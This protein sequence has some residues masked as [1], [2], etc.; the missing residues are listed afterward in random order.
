MKNVPT[1]FLPLVLLLFSTSFALDEQPSKGLLISAVGLPGSGKSSVMKEL[2]TL[3]DRTC[4]CEPDEKDWADAVLAKYMSGSFTMITWF[5]SMRVPQLYRAHQLRTI[6]EIAITDSYYDKLLSCYIGKPGM[7]WLI[8]P[9][10]PYF[11]IMVA[12]AKKDW[13]YLPTADLLIFFDISYDIWK[14]F[15]TKRNRL[16]EIDPKFLESY[17]TQKLLYDACKKLA[18]EK[19]VTLITIHQE[20]SSPRAMAEKIR[21]ILYE[22][23]I[24]TR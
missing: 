3:I 10:D 2:A 13:E 24:I 6:G 7:E 20:N 16:L 23:N 9:N 22:K 1:I 11:D 12:I 17:S 14:E 4:F 19:N 8:R 5:R 18:N 15:L 21:D